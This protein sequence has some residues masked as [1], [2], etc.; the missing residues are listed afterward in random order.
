MKQKKQR[1]TFFY[2]IC[3]GRYDLPEDATIENLV[4]EIRK[5]Y[6]S[7]VKPYAADSYLE[8]ITKAI[9]NGFSKEEYLTSFE[10]VGL[11]FKEERIDD[12]HS[13]WKYCLNDLN[14]EV[15]CFHEAWSEEEMYRYVL[16]D[17]FD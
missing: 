11:R 16:I 8:S 14:D 5:D 12:F 9:V 15:R 10:I 17:E 1:N 13:N 6:L 3:N 4:E 2:G 7:A